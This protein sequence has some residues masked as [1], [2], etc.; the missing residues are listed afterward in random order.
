MMDRSELK[1]RQ[2][3]C[4]AIFTL[5]EEAFHLMEL[6]LEVAQ[7]THISSM[8]GEKDLPIWLETPYYSSFDKHNLD[9][10][11]GKPRGTK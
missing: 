4:R 8:T 7:K 5:N 3:L 6:F 9:S 11:F 1:R 2:A 10:P